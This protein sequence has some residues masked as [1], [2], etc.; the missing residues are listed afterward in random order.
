MAYQSLRTLRNELTGIRLAAAD[1]SLWSIVATVQQRARVALNDALRSYPFWT[2]AVYSSA[3]LSDPVQIIPLPPKVERVVAIKAMDTTLGT[4]LA[5]K[6]Y[7][8]LPQGNTNLITISVS[9]QPRESHYLEIQYEYRLEAFPE[10]VNLAAVV[11]SNASIISVVNPHTLAQEWE[12]QGFLEIASPNNTYAEVVYYNSI[13]P[14]VGFHVTRGQ[15]GTIP[16]YWPASDSAYATAV[17]N[18]PPEALSVIMAAAEANMY[19]FWVSHRALYDQYTSLVG[20]Q[21]LEIAELLGII[22]TTEDRADRRYKRVRRPP[23]PGQVRVR[24]RSD[25]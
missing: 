22:R 3:V 12:P 10:Q 2:Q 7:L 15:L 11:A 21:Q 6:D 16:R 14:N 25:V 19:A 18:V 23:A 17:T 9:R 20:L 13:D 5:P 8:H 24:R 4:M 1:T